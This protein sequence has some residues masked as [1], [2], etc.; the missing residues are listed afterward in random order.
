MRKQS[1]LLSQATGGCVVRVGTAGGPANRKQLL[2][3]QA[4]ALGCLVCRW[5]GQKNAWGECRARYVLLVNLKRHA[6][7][8]AHRRALQAASVADDLGAG[9][10]AVAVGD[11]RHDVPCFNLCF[12]AYKGAQRGA[13][14]TDYA[15]DLALSRMMGAPVPTSRSSRMTARQLVSCFGVVLME[16]D[17]AL[18]EEA[19]HISL[20]MDLRKN[21]AVVR[22]RMALKRLPAGMCAVQNLSEAEGPGK[23]AVASLVGNLLIHVIQPAHSSFN[24][25]V[26]G[27]ISSPC[28][29]QVSSAR[30]RSGTSAAHTFCE[31]TGF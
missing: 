1:F 2:H 10:E 8:P 3:R 11:D 21:F 24:L 14:Y 19:T 20:S 9:L 6:A 18:L 22:A 26:L 28:L 5:Y 29:R 12:A 27:R 7:K 4:W 16:E 13:A 31:Q 30:A 17:R 23:D 25:E 15:E